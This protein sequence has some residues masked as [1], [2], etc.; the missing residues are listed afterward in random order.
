MHEMA[1]AQRILQVVLDAAGD[2]EVRRFRVHIGRLQMVVPDSLRFS[3][4]LV[5]EGTA[6]AGAVLEM[7]ETPARLQCGQC[8]AE[9]GLDL[10]PFLCRHCGASEIEVLSG[11]EVM[12]DAIELES[13]E[14]IRSR[15]VPAEPMLEPRNGVHLAAYGGEHDEQH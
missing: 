8:G 3:F 11:D 4:E 15:E 10:P 5:G 9:S 2:Q 7:E 13:G 6:A 12:V 1:L 14:T